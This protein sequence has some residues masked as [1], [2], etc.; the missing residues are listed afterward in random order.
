MPGRHASGGHDRTSALSLHLSQRVRET[1]LLTQSSN[2]DM[3]VKLM[4]SSSITGV[5]MNGLRSTGH[6]QNIPQINTQPVM[7]KVRYD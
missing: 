5:L 1:R 7:R 3:P 6:V 2:T 4:F